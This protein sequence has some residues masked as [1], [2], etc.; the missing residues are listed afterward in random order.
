MALDPER[1][2]MIVSFA[3]VPRAHS[4][5]IVQPFEAQGLNGH[6]IRLPYQMITGAQPG[7]MEQRVHFEI[8][9]LVRAAETM[10]DWS[11]PAAMPITLADVMRD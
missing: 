7:D 6:R 9:R 10:T 8:D 5:G 11:Q 1:V 3:I 4:Y 2:E